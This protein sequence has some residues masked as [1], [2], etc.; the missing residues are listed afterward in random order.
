MSEWRL[1][2]LFI[3]AGPTFSLPITIVAFSGSPA[4]R[5]PSASMRPGSPDAHP[6]AAQRDGGRL[7]PVS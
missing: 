2:G 1:G 4:C 3:V 7:R 6:A 5:K